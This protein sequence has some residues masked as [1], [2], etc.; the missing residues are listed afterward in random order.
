M[1]RTYV[2]TLIM[3]AALVLAAPGFAQAQSPPAKPGQQNSPNAQADPQAAPSPAEDLTNQLTALLNLDAGQSQRVR[4]VLEDEH[5][6]MVALVSDPSTSDEDKRAGLEVIRSKAS[7]QIMAILTPAQQQK[8]INTL[9]SQEQQDQQQ[10]AP[11]PTQ[12]PPQG[13]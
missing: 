4:N 7:D 6:K 2:A 11:P 10:Q 3:A 12:P 8:L 1:S 9:R 5:G 13:R